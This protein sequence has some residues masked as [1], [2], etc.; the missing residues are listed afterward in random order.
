MPHPI[1]IPLFCAFIMPRHPYHNI[2]LCCDCL[3]YSSL[4]CS[5]SCE[6]GSAFTL[7]PLSSQ[8]LVLCLQTL[9]T[10]WILIAWMV[11][12]MREWRTGGSL[13]LS[14]TGSHS[15]ESVVPQTPLNAFTCLPFLLLKV[16][17][18]HDIVNSCSD[19]LPSVQQSY[20][21]T[22]SCWWTG[23]LP[24]SSLKKD[25]DWGRWRCPFRCDQL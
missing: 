15:A 4:A 19:D 13:F 3:F 5:E 6:P 7:L 20:A 17:V 22:C 18:V 25:E 8:R 11:G 21:R 14:W 1:W 10:Q 12:W 2:S 23:Y 9:G 16:P 24:T